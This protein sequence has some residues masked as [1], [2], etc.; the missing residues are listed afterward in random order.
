[1]AARKSY[2]YQIKGRKLSLLQNQYQYGSGQTLVADP[3][4]DDIGPTGK[5]SWISPDEAVA[6]GIEIEYAYS[7]SYRINDASDTVSMTG[8]TESSALGTLGLLAITV[9]SIT[10]LADEW[11]LIAGSEKWNG[12]HQVNIGVTSG[13]NVILKTKYNG[14]AVTDKNATIYH[15]VSVMEDESFE[16]DL[17]SYLTKAL[18]YY[19][20][21]KLSEDQMDLER[22]EY[23]MREFKKLVEKY[24]SSKQSGPRRV[25]GFGMTR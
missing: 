16:L 12:L 22:K 19:V 5:P 14:A 18:V 10:V 15:D 13:T 8:Y 1:M 21:A 6:D 3:P 4:L 11:I 24:E 23:F 2:A 20:K 17:P 7:P 9:G 25:M